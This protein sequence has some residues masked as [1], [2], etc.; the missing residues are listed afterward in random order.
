VKT[1]SFVIFFLIVLAIYGS[2]N[3]YIFIRGWQALSANQ[4]IRSFYL[5]SFLCV[6][7]SFVVGRILERF[8]LSLLTDILVWVGSFWLAAMLYFFL[9]VIIL[10]L[11]RLFNHF[12]PWYPDLL[13]H[14]YGKTKLITMIASC[15]LVA[16]TIIAGR[17]NALNPKVR[18]INITIPKT[19]ETPKKLNLVVASDIHLGSLI[20]KNRLDHLVTLINSLKPDIVLLAGDIVDEDIGAVI[21]ENLGESLRSIKAPL[22]IYAIT[23]NHEYI[24]GVE[25]ACKYLN[26][27]GII[28]LRD[29]VI[30]VGNKITIIGREDRSIRGFAGKDRATLQELVSQVDRNQPIILLDHQ[31]FHLMEASDNGIDLQISGHTHH[32]QLWPLSYITDLVYE[33]SNGFK[34]IGNTQVYVSPG[35]GTWGPPVRIGNRPEIVNFIIQFN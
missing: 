9:I 22:G 7:L 10:D 26:A 27:H 28:M 13:T 34:Q 11:A 5:I 2:I 17:I 4:L 21:R 35:F 6:S 31:P 24:G 33:V 3:F 8:S 15:G 14:N 19:V 12:L 32:G 1:S 29:S 20:G 18:T 16:L 23:G 25:Q 30:S